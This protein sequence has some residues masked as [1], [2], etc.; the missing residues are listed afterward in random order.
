[1]PRAACHGHTHLNQ[2]DAWFSQIFGVFCVHQH[3]LHWYYIC[4][5]SFFPI[6]VSQSLSKDTLG[7]NLEGLFDRPQVLTRLFYQATISF[8]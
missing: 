6:L 3:D 5:E 8:V 1:M 2:L 4:G 7:I